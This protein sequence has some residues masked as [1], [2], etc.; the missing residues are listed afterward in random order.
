[1]P[2]QHQK[3]WDLIF[4]FIEKQHTAVLFVTICT[5]GVFQIDAVLEFLPL[6]LQCWSCIN[7]KITGQIHANLHI[8][9]TEDIAWCKLAATQWWAKQFMFFSLWTCILLTYISIVQSYCKTDETT[10]QLFK[11][12]KSCNDIQ[13][14][15]RLKRFLS[16]QQCFDAQ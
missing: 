12:K 16:I 15:S 7:S 10:A 13:D 6:Q 5:I 11:K 3:H 1:M 14:N 2:H 4:F 8:T 9:Y